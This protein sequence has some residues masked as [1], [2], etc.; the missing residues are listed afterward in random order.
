MIALVWLLDADA[1]RVSAADEMPCIVRPA[2]LVREW[3]SLI[4]VPDGRCRHDG[5]DPWGEYRSLLLSVYPEL[6]GRN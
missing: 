3:C 2:A 1:I 5:S 4:A 6:V